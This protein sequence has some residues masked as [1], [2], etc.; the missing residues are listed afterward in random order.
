MLFLS[1][2]L[3]EELSL[4]DLN[5]FFRL[6]CSF[7]KGMEIIQGTFLTAPLPSSWTW[8]WPSQE[9]L[10]GMLAQPQVLQPWGEHLSSNQL[11][12]FAFTVWQR[13]WR[14]VNTQNF[15]HQWEYHISYRYRTA[16][17]SSAES[18][19]LA[20]CAKSKH[21]VLKAC[22]KSHR[23]HLQVCFLYVLIYGKEQFSLGKTQQ[24]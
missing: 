2:L 5:F 19:L 8:D 21:S 9:Q 15:G 10:Q 3:Y 23:R 11:I 13:I 12:Q 24:K 4:S 7:E 6:N 16:L 22:V 14:T 18:P 17:Q 1:H 20:T